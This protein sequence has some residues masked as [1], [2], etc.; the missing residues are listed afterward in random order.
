MAER[1]YAATSI[2]VLSRETGLP[3]SAIYHHFRSK[4][5]LLAAVMESGLR[6]FFSAMN[7][8]HANPPE[9]GS[10]RDRLA[11]FLERTD[12]V[13]AE[14]Q[15]FLRLH[16]LLVLSG[17][18]SEVEISETLEQVRRDGR[19]E[20]NYMIREAFRDEGP[21]VAQAVADRLDYFGIA[22]VDGAFLAHQADPTD[23][24][25]NQHQL[26]ADALALIGAQIAA[27]IRAGN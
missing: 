19:A 2:S 27:E 4:G 12:E 21:Q 7:D 3:K 9:G 23:P 25:A 26:L 1:G 17:E 10:P 6:D 20:M 18:A 13:L 22:G 11:W 14:R 15:E 24:G 8:A 16:M 5:G